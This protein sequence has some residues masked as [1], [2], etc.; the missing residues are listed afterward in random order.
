[1]AI[2]TVNELLCFT[3]VQYDKLDRTNLNSILLDFYSREEVIFAKN[4]LLAECEKV[5]LSGAIN[6]FK[7]NRIGANVEQKVVKDILDIWEVVD[8]EKGGKLETEFVA[9]DVN[10]LPSA[11]ANKFTIQFLVS[12][13]VQLEERGRLQQASLD[14]ITE[15]LTS[16]HHKLSPHSDESFPTTGLNTS[17]ASPLPPLPPAP[18]EG[19][20]VTGAGISTLDVI[21]INN[22]K[23]KSVDENATPYAP[24]KRGK[25][26]TPL[27]SSATEETAGT[28]GVAS[29]AIATS[30]FTPSAEV[31]HIAA[32]ATLSANSSAN[33]LANPLANLSANLSASALSSRPTASASLG[34]VSLP[35]A[36]ASSSLDPAS[37][38][39]A[40]ASSSITPKSP[41]LTPA[42]SVHAP[43]PSSVALSSSASDRLLDAAPTPET[44]SS[45]TSASTEIASA[46]NPLTPRNASRSRPEA[47]PKNTPKSFAAKAAEL[48]ARKDKFSLANARNQRNVTTVKGS[49]VKG[50]DSEL[51]GVAPYVRDY[52]EISVTRLA[53]TTTA[54]QIKSHLHKKGIEVKDV[55]I[56]SSKIKGTKSAKVRVL[57]EHKS[58]VKAPEIWPTHCRVSDWINLR[59][60]TQN[61]P[62]EAPKSQGS[63][64]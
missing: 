43:A 40:P 1:M 42:S 61:G 2:H 12:K 49:A 38:P 63:R 28:G 13:I 21:V 26:E 47:G 32:S 23:R 10:R 55:F 20:A 16:L 25:G 54:D 36:P 44:V 8:T 45:L 41:S 62:T 64:S 57:V 22:R 31:D 6:E 9:S 58:R 33:P 4:V 17:L 53:E 29:P 34:Q 56:L 27:P 3:S 5:N 60:R 50:V 30:L 48:A 39:L 19:A 7:K 51:E 15:S 14:N 35:I 59:K 11:D 37:S 18:H 24:S 46:G 52:W